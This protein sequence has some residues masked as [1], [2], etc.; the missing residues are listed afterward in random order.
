MST[1]INAKAQS[2]TEDIFDLEEGLN[3]IAWGHDALASLLNG[4]GGSSD[5][6]VWV[7]DKLR[8]ESRALQAKFAGIVHKKTRK[9][10]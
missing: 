7:G 10:G 1:R 6:V 9:K 4:C 8:G 3:R 2:K 5:S